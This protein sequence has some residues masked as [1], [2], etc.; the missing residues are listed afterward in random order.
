MKEEQLKT[1]QSSWKEYLIAYDK[2]TPIF[3]E[4]KE[5]REKAEP[6]ITKAKDFLKKGLK[7]QANATYI[8]AK[9]LL[10]KAEKNERVARKIFQDALLKLM[11]SVDKVFMHPSSIKWEGMESATLEDA[12]NLTR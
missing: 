8:K 5:I 12:T 3:K 9:E 11:N 10:K 2:S 6:I 1:I 7:D 4:A